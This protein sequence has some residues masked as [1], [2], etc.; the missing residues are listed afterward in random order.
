MKSW[1]NKEQQRTNFGF[2]AAQL[3]ATLSSVI[4]DDGATVVLPLASV[5]DKQEGLEA[6]VGH[7]LGKGSSTLEEKVSQGRHVWLF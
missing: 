5:A 6:T 1:T 3:G 2:A 4:I 7:A